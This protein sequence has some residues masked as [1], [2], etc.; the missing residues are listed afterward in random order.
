[1]LQ[2][3]Q[4]WVFSTQA[5]RFPRPGHPLLRREQNISST[6]SQNQPEQRRKQ[7]QGQLTPFSAS[8]E[9]IS[10]SCS[11]ARSDSGPWSMRCSRSRTWDTTLQ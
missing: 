6:C 5:E 10:S 7:Q 1:M 11:R 9:N 2:K 3:K 8:S 4:R